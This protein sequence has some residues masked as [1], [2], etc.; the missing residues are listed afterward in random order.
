MFCKAVP[1][2]VAVI[3]AQSAAALKK[4]K[5]PRKGKDDGKKKAAAEPVKLPINWSE[6]AVLNA[7]GALHLLSFDDSVKA[8][9]SRAGG[10]PLLLKLMTSRNMQIYENCVGALWNT[11]LDINNQQALKKAKAYD[12][13]VQPV[14][15]C[16]SIGSA[17]DLGGT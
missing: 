1:A 6:V 8:E 16:W 12:F 13:L 3:A 11:G 9:I 4:P 5:G 7:S 14:P 17:G 10:I 2:L 15:E